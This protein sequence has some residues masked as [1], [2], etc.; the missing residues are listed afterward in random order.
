MSRK[1]KSFETREYMERK[2]DAAHQEIDAMKQKLSIIRI[3]RALER[4][5]PWG[6]DGGLDSTEDYEVLDA[7]RREADCALELVVREQGLCRTIHICRECGRSTAL[8]SGRFFDRRLAFREGG[9]YKHAGDYLCS[10]CWCRLDAE[11]ADAE[12]ER[13]QKEKANDRKAK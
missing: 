1:L 3:H 2:I 5:L 13:K 4:G 9:Q 11:K 10:E 8:G 12:Y 6:P 7:A